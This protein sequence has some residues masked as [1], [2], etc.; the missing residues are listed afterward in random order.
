[1]SVAASSTLTTARVARRSLLGFALLAVVVV[2]AFFGSHRVAEELRAALGQ[3]GSADRGWVALALC[4][5]GASIGFAVATW[6]VATRSCGARGT[7]L[8]ATFRFGVGAIVQILTPAR[9]G[10]AVRVA[11]FARTV[12]EDRPVLRVGGAYAMIEAARAVALGVLL[13]LAWA[14]GGM[15]F[16]PVTIVAGIALLVV[17]S[18]A[19]VARRTT[20]GPFGRILAAA[21][22]LRAEPR[23][24]AALL[25]AA[26]ASAAMRV[27]GA[28]ALAAAVG[29]PAP[30]VAGLVACCAVDLAGLL[31]L[32]PGNVGIA[33]G[34]VAVALT[35]RGVHMAPALALGILF[36]GSESSV[37]LGLGTVSLLGFGGFPRARRRRLAF[38]AIAAA[39]SGAAALL[40]VTFF[41]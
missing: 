28:S 21:H 9:L 6:W 4:G 29:I 12:D 39:A 18:I 36:Q 24:A 25:G 17:A 37:S 15:S 16:W 41:A 13:A 10:D 19:V 31:P 14:V 22:E 40:G 2:P 38:V 35:A 27:L 1:M 34:A 5:F 26:C 33:S 20:R 30:L 11:L 8:D 3:L 7:R 23:A 32:T